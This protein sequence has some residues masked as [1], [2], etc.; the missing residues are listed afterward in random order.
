VLEGWRGAS[1]SYIGGPLPANA[2]GAAPIRHVWF[3]AKSS[4]GHTTR[5]V[6][7]PDHPV[8]S[9]S[10]TDYKLTCISGATSWARSSSKSMKTS[11]R[12]RKCRPYSGSGHTAATSSQD[13]LGAKR[14]DRIKDGVRERRQHSPTAGATAAMDRRSVACDGAA[15]CR[16][17]WPHF[18][19]GPWRGGGRSPG[20]SGR[21]RRR[22]AASRSLAA[23]LDVSDATSEAAI[24]PHMRSRGGTTQTARLLHRVR[25]SNRGVTAIHT[26]VDWEGMAG[27]RLD[28][29]LAK[30]PR[31]ATVRRPGPPLLAL[32]CPA[33][34]RVNCA[35]VAGKRATSWRPLTAHEYRRGMAAFAA[36]WR[37]N[38]GL[39]SLRA[40][41]STPMS[42][43]RC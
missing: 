35:R 6:G 2:R 41:S 11:A 3:P 21:F 24:V 39:S 23:A 15:T 14:L 18:A 17:R 13:G 12:R 20:G 32:P 29:R 38:G 16:R 19:L 37:Q 22:S 43:H 7:V 42:F 25:P 33:M 5:Q 9:R 28:W 30:L 4:N 1:S 34:G 10:E 31:R 36:Y 8:S 26:R 27:W 40:R